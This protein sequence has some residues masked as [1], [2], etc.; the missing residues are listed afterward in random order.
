[1]R[2]SSPAISAGPRVGR[3][4]VDFAGLYAHAFDYFDDWQIGCAAEQFGEHAFVFGG[5]MLDDEV[6]HAR[7]GG[8]APR[9]WEMASS[10]PAEAPMPTIMNWGMASPSW[11]GLAILVTAILRF[12]AGPLGAVFLRVVALRCDFIL[13]RWGIGFF[14]FFAIRR[15]VGD[16]GQALRRR[17]VKAQFSIGRY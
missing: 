1:M 8:S 4:N 17:S 9:S 6:G 3:D 2:A 14:I 16:A 11:E 5:E 15:G 13:S 12:E 10:L 7:I